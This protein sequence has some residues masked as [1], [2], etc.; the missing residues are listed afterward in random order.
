MNDLDLLHGDAKTIAAFLGCTVR[1]VQ[2]YKKGRPLPTHFRKLLALRFGDLSALM[3]KDWE[4]FYFGRDG[5]MYL[6]TYRNGFDPHQIRALFFNVQEV[7]ALRNEVKA[8][9]ARIW[10]HDK[11]KSLGVLPSRKITSA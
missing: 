6:P 1:M 5:K 11:V 8:L 2:L 7:A 9:K 3:G 10:A 4:G